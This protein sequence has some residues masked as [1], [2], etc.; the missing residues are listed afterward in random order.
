MKVLKEL[1]AGYG[2][3]L[4]Q[5]DP[6]TQKQYQELAQKGQSPKIMVIGCCDSRVSPS[7]IF[8]EEPGSVFTVRNV[9]NLVPPFERD[10]AF[11][12]TSAA[13]E[14][15]VNHLHVE[16]IVIM[17]HS[18]CG[19]VK[20]GLQA[21]LSSSRCDKSFFIEGWVSMIRAVVERIVSDNPDSDSDQI[22]PMIERDSI[23]NSL[24]NLK[25]F[26]FVAEAVERG[27]LGLHGLYFDIG[28]GALHALNQEIDDFVKLG[29][30]DS[31]AA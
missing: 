1:T 19:G 5:T 27:A 21:V 11:H 26:P 9:G 28:S 7:L 6:K 2:Q 20:A 4:K 8:N 23:K 12:G 14:F 10:N 13:I 3:F 16:H 15:A 17:G 22:L 29:E 25:S 31:A 18:H 24:E 30:M